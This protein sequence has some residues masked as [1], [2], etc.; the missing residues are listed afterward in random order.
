MKES[1]FFQKLIRNGFLEEAK[2]KSETRTKLNMKSIFWTFGILLVVIIILILCYAP[3]ED[4]RS[5]STAGAVPDYS[6]PVS[7]NSSAQGSASGPA[8]NGGKDSTVPFGGG[9]I[10]YGV[11]SEQVSKS[12]RNRNSAQVIRRGSGGN[13]PGAQIPIGTLIGARLINTVRSTNTASPVIAQILQDVTNDNG[14]SIPANTKAIGSATFDETSKRIQIRFS[15]LVYED[16]SQHGIQ[17]T[18][19]MQDGSAGIDGDYH[20]GRTEQQLGRFVGNFIG[21]LADGLRTQSTPGMFGSATQEG[22]IKNG[23]LGGVAQ[24]AQ[25]QA[26][27]YSDDLTNT[28]PSMSIDA[29]TAFYLFLDKE[30]LP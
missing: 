16:G 26:H 18:A 30:Y 29:G 21:G 6:K 14:I 25:D 10:G 15:T 2:F 22:S 7:P 24:S 27:V 3:N 13:D 8:Q 23:L 20:S 28:R 12:S 11:A 5:I 1:N 4:S 17:A 19:M 9:G